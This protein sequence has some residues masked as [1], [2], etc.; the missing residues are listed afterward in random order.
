VEQSANA[1]YIRKGLVERT[2]TMKA[3]KTMLVMIRRRRRK[4]TTIPEFLL[5]DDIN[6]LD[7]QMLSLFPRAKWK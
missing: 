2:G 6:Q 3:Q 4:T 5:V 7:E 1:D